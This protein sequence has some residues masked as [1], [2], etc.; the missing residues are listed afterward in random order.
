MKFKQ[1]HLFFRAF[2]LGSLLDFWSYWSEWF[3]RLLADVYF[4]DFGLVTL[5]G[6]GVLFLWLLVVNIASRM[7]LIWNGWVLATTAV[8]IKRSY[9]LV[10][11]LQFFLCS[12]CLAIGAL[13]ALSD[14]KHNR[15]NIYFLSQLWWLLL[16]FVYWFLSPTTI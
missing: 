7:L 13:L 9:I 11:V 8:V 4:E 16:Y 14:L 5:W 12:T 1:F 15:I 2:L 3:C 6:A 10:L